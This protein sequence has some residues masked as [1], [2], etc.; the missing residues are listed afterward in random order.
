MEVRYDII[1]VP[2]FYS[3]ASMKVQQCN[4]RTSFHHLSGPWKFDENVCMCNTQPL[5]SIH[6]HPVC[7][8]KRVRKYAHVWVGASVSQRM[9]LLWRNV[10]V[11]VCKKSESLHL[12][13]RACGSWPVLRRI[14]PHWPS[15]GQRQNNCLYFHTASACSCAWWTIFHTAPWNSCWSREKQRVKEKRRKTCLKH[16]QSIFK[17][18][19]QY[20]LTSHKRVDL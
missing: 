19:L 8:S 13:W 11:F 7:A 1:D 3:S 16:T 5:F 14:L 15:G 20:N 9:C 4:F 17:N 18:N 2:F 12:P 6:W 10:F